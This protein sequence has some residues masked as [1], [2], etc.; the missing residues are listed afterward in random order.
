MNISE[1]EQHRAKLLQEICRFPVFR[2]G[3]LTTRYR[4]CGKNNCHCT[5]ENSKGHGPSWTITRKVKGKT[6]AKYIRVEM[7]EETKEQIQNYHDFHSTIT[8]LIETNV[9]ICDAKLEANRNA[10]LEAKK[11]GST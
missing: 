7:L 1:L 10:S 5:A 2:P 4:K 11:K 3:T 6:V 8:Q 9:K